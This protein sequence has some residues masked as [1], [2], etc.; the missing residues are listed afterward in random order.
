MTPSPFYVFI[1]S[2]LCCFYMVRAHHHLHSFPTRRSSDLRGLHPLPPAL[3]ASDVQPRAR[4]EIVS[5]PRPRWPL[6]LRLGQDRKSTRLNSSHSQISYAV[7]CLKK[8]TPS[9]LY[10][11]MP[12]N[13]GCFFIVRSYYPS[14][15]HSD[16]FDFDRF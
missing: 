8:K 16:Y 9:Q 12:P 10:V 11:F 6:Q 1:P 7:F 5:R 15:C 2:Y 14:E 4:R 13:H 3:P